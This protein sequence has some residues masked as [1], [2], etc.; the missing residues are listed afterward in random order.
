MNWSLP[1]LLTLADAPLITENKAA[2]C[3]MTFSFFH[4]KYA[5]VEC[6][7]VLSASGLKSLVCEVLAKH[8]VHTQNSSLEPQINQCY[9]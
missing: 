6:V 4:N 3:D 8:K 2:Y 1:Y 9:E 7:Y 5:F